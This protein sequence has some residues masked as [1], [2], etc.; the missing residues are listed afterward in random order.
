[1]DPESN[2]LEGVQVGG[3]RGVGGIEMWFGRR[4]SMG[5]RGSLEGVS[6]TEKRLGRWDGEAAWKE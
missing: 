4:G 2:G 3:L 6:G 1:M 5:Q